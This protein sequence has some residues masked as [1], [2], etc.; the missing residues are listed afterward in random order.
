MP[1]IDGKDGLFSIALND[2]KQ[3][4]WKRRS[5]QDFKIEPGMVAHCN[6]RSWEAEAKVSK[7]QSQAWLCSESEPPP[8]KRNKL[9]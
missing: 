3:K 7:V 2:G 5:L 4:Q 1:N 8:P 9:E 6:S